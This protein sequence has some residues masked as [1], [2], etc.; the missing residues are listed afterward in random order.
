[1]P[2]DPCLLA[3]TQIYTNEI[4]R[5]LKQAAQATAERDYA[6]TAHHVAKAAELMDYRDREILGADEFEN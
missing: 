5:E 2:K 4:D 3:V 6:V 1:M